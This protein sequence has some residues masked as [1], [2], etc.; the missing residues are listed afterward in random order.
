VLGQVWGNSIARPS[1]GPIASQTAASYGYDWVGNRLNP[2]SDASAMV[3]NSA[4][5]LVKW[6]GMHGDATHAGYVYDGAGNL[7]QVKDASGSVTVA[8]YTYTPAGLMEE[9]LMGRCRQPHKAW[10]W[11]KNR[12]TGL[13]GGLPPRFHV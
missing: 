13:H 6:P 12:P 3:Y 7:T 2:P 1:P 11:H 9:E 8:S 10:G 4:D 5:Q